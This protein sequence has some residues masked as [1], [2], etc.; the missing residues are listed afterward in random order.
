MEAV[1]LKKPVGALSDPYFDEH[2]L[3]KSVNMRLKKFEAPMRIIEPGVEIGPER[4]SKGE[5]SEKFT[6]RLL[7]GKVGLHLLVRDLHGRQLHG[8]HVETDPTPANTT[9]SPGVDLLVGFLNQVFP[10]QWES[11]GCYVYKRISGTNTFSDHAYVQPG[12][13]C[14]RALDVHPHTIPIGDAIEAAVKGEPALA[15]DLRYVLWR[16]VPNHYPNHLHFS[17]EDGGYPGSC[18]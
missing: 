9:G 13:W 1:R 18:R 14:G 17:F 8:R 11:W 10:S 16:G 7:A 5:V 6:K 2:A 12:K 15:R 4:T 3:R